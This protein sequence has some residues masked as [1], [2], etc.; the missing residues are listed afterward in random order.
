MAGNP[1]HGL[2][3]PA[4]IPP[5]TFCVERIVTSQCG[6][7]E[8]ART[9][10]VARVVFVTLRGGPPLIHGE[11]PT[12]DLPLVMTEADAARLAAM[13]DHADHWACHENGRPT[14]GNG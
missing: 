10:V 5:D 7:G 11:R 9:G 2:P 6:W 1:W 4:R 8:D 12:I 13:L 14:N 3:E